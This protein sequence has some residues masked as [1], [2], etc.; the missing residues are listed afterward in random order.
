L[1]E[2]VEAVQ[3]TQYGVN[4]GAP[5]P[6]AGVQSRLTDAL[7]SLLSGRREARLPAAGPS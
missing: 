1:A 6:W 3:R 5:L 4:G 7:V 2:L